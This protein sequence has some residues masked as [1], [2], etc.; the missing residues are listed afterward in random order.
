MGVAASGMED[1]EEVAAAAAEAALVAGAMA[2]TVATCIKQQ[3]LSKTRR[4]LKLSK[5]HCNTA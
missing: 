2:G 5:M 1:G 3:I 4:S